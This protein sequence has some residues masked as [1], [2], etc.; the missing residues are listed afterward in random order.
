M[1]EESK[2]TSDVIREKCAAAIE[3]GPKTARQLS[4]VIG[5]S[6]RKISLVLQWDHAAFWF[7]GRKWNIKKKVK[8]RMNDKFDPG[9]AYYGLANKH[10]HFRAAGID[11]KKQSVESELA[12]V[13]AFCDEVE[14]R[15]LIDYR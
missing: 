1:I 5:I 12:I 10:F 3:S 8:V 13:R 6:A 4:E 9:K 2:M 7:D 14:R 11:T 15:A